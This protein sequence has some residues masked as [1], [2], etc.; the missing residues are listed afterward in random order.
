[1]A[2]TPATETYNEAGNNDSSRRTVWLTSWP[3]PKQPKCGHDLAKFKREPGRVS[4]T[5]LETAA[6]MSSWVTPR[7]KDSECAGGHRGMRDSLHSQ[8]LLAT[9]ATPA[10]RDFRHA[11]A[12]SYKERSESTKGEQL[13]NLVVHSGPTPN[14][15]P[16]PTERRGQLNPAFSRW[17]MGLP[18]EWDDCAATATLSSRRKRSP[19][20]KP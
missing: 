12:R 7:G 6:L 13:C 15:S 16:A 10:E 1:M 19:S 17:L 14:G 18:D 20:S 11:N 2:G 5:D 8:S 3:T 4:P 9:W